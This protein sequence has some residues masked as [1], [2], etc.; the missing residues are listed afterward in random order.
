MKAGFYET[1]ITPALGMERPGDYMKAFVRRFHDPLKV[2]AAVI[3]DGTEKVALVGVDTCSLVSVGKIIEV[4]KG[5]EDRCGIRADHVLIA[6]SHTHAGGPFEGALREDVEGAP[7]LVKDLM[8]NRSVAADP[9]YANWVM[10]QIRT[11]VC[12]AD[13]RLQEAVLS[14]GSGCES[15][16]V[17]NRR[18]RMK[19]GRTYTNPGRG[20]PDVL[21]P[22]GPVD[23]EVGV[24]SAWT[25]DG[26]LLGC[27]TNFACH[28]TTFAYGAGTSAD[29]IA[30]L[31]HTVKSAMSPQAVVVF[32]NGGCGD[33]CQSSEAP[34]PP[35]GAP[36]YE[37]QET[38]SRFVGTRVG[39]EALKVMVTAQRGEL[40][41]V[42]AATT[43]LTLQ[44]RKPDPERVERSRRLVAEGIRTGQTST[45]DWIFAKEIAILDYLMSR[46][47]TVEVEVQAVQMGPAV[48]LANPAEYFCQ[49]GLDIKAASPFPFTYIVELANGCVG[50]VPTEEAFSSTGGGYETV[51][52]SY[53]NLEIAAGTRIAEASISLAKRL[54]PGAVPR[55]PEPPPFKDAWS[56][57]V[58]G[59]DR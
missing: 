49:L 50:Y 28:G 34:K 59:P 57:G 31:E 15:A 48:F 6:A 41:P 54:T 52:T 47:P 56:Y 29:W 58:L 25:L 20:N 46:E 30:N 51:L 27:I 3:S 1:D 14:V 11:T 42:A 17:A 26:R 2:R 35:P 22:A 55:G 12:E 44:R 37:S 10:A 40:G 43:M 45:T 16:A 8:L 21:G 4:R 32:L 53:S 7:E 5:I 9:L 24:L 39:A 13:A 23:P 18:Y 38:V 33:V 36:L 19:N